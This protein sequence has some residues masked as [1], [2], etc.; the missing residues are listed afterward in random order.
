GTGTPTNLSNNGFN[1]ARPAWSPDGTKIAYIS[2]GGGGGIFIMDADGMNPTLVISGS[3]TP[4][5]SPDGT[6]IAF[7]RGNPTTATTDIF[8]MNADGTAV[9]QLTFRAG[10]DFFADWGI[11]R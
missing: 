4:T 3:A 8:V 5:W 1:E 2:S 11:I 9:T 10:N 7:R 6:R